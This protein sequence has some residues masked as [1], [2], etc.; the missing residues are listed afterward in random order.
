MLMLWRKNKVLID[1]VI[2]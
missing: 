1:F 2:R